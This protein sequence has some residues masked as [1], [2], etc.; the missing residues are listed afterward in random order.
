M[1]MKMAQPE[2][3]EVLR[4]HAMWLRLEMGGVRANLRGANLRRADLRRA[5]LRVADLQRADLQRADL[6]SADIDYATWP[7]WCGSVGVRVD[8]RIAYQL[9]AHLCAVA[10]DDPTV[11]AMQG[12][13]LPWARK[14]HR[15]AECELLGGDR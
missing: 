7:L 6:R 5:D 12:A 10:C 14:S 13:L 8:A 3:S 4:L 1:T 9:A 11:Q 15:A 2:L